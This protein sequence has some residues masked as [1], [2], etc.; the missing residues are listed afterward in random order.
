MINL[1]TNIEGKRATFGSVQDEWMKYDVNLGGHWEYD[2]GCFDTIL[3]R[4]G[5]E[6]I[7]L[8]IPFRVIEGVLD[9]YNASIEFQKPFVL[10]HIVNLGIDKDENS[11]LSAT[12]I[13]QFQKPIDT[14]GPIKKKSKWEEAGEK[15]V[16]RLM[17][18]VVLM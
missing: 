2:G 13:N 3:N 1:E 8:R 4:E 6:T 9:D 15:E 5:G 10:K 12:G 16:A 17:K 11:I 7:Y 18:K 14:D